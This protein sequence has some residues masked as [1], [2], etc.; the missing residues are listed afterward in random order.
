MNTAE[1][2][3]KRTKGFADL[4]IKLEW[5]VGTKD[6][7]CS[8]R[9]APT[10]YQQPFE[11]YTNDRSLGSGARSVHPTIG[12]CTECADCPLGEMDCGT[13]KVH[14]LLYWPAESIAPRSRSTRAATAISGRTNV[15]QTSSHQ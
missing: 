7:R 9:N 1:I 14:P 11:E 12:R 2:A 5:G 8:M 4:T 3:S 10:T 6:M 15:D 13:S